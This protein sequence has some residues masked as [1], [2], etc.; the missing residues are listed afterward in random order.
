MLQRKLAGSIF[1]LAAIA[2]SSAQTASSAA[3][4]QG[5]FQNPNTP[6][7]ARIAPGSIPQQQPMWRPGQQMQTKPSPQV[8]QA[9]PNSVEPTTGASIA[10]PGATNRA[11]QSAITNTAVARPVNTTMPGNKA[12]AINGGMPV[13][14]ALVGSAGRA[15]VDYRGGLLSVI[16]ENA[17][18]GKLMRLIGNKTGAQIDVAPDVA[19][20]LVMAHLG[21]ASP[22]EVLT[23]LLDSSHLT[24]I[25][26]GEDKV[27]KVMIRRRYGSAAPPV[28]ARHR[29]LG[30]PEPGASD[31]ANA[32]P[33]QP[34]QSQSGEIRPAGEMAPPAIASRSPL[35]PSASPQ[36]KA[37]Q[38]T[39]PD[40]NIQPIESIDVRG[41]VGGTEAPDQPESNPP[42]Q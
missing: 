19:N 32:Q 1:L 24:Y 27:S 12:P 33:E 23:G 17:E 25:M 35:M 13:P 29:N 9:Q 4:P 34:A 11:S 8:A 31:Q 15:G 40:G 16:A 36:G 3:Q 6:A 20:E 18:L 42:Q 30:F 21:P 38:A 39:T 41:Q 2:I 22:N 5:D 37:E 26:I 7:A 14:Q 10:W 28:V